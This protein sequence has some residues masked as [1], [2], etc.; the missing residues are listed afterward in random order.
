MSI[1][2]ICII[3][4]PYYNCKILI[5]KYVNQSLLSL[6][7]WLRI[8]F[9][10]KLC[11]KIRMKGRENWN[12]TRYLLNWSSRRN[13]IRFSRSRS[14]GSS[15]RRRISLRNMIK[16]RRRPRQESWSSN[17]FTCQWG[18]PIGGGSIFWD[19]FS[20]SIASSK[21]KTLQNLDST[22]DSTCKFTSF[23]WR[24]ST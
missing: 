12:S 21:Y 22:T 10:G 13:W 1:R 14:P 16:E 8:Y 6:Q 17:K 2:L 18:Q 7:K 19:R 3:L 9:Q 23:S 4:C 11:R 20:T 15:K 5:N 24:I